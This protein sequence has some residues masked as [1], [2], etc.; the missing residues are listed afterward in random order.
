MSYISDH[1]LFTDIFISY[2][3]DVTFQNADTYLAI[4]QNSNA[5]SSNTSYF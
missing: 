3:M 5:P 1:I 4:Y 2:H